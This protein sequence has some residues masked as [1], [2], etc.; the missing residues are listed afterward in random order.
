MSISFILDLEDLRSTTV[1]DVQ[2]V[3]SISS[4]IIILA[5]IARGTL[6]HQTPGKIYP[7][8]QWI[9]QRFVDATNR[10][11]NTYEQQKPEPGHEYVLMWYTP[12][13]VFSK[14]YEHNADSETS[15]VRIHLAWL[16]RRRRWS[17]LAGVEGY[18]SPDARLIRGR[19]ATSYVGQDRATMAYVTVGS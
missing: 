3:E 11:V 19:L 2:T 16:N 4:K 5:T 13:D 1:N 14:T 6:M 10:Y 15:S 7:C 9:I 12:T 18:V 8:R 17:T